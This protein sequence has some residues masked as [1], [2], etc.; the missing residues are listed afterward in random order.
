MSLR[1]GVTVNVIDSSSRFR[2]SL[3]SDYFWF[4]FTIVFK[5]EGRC[6]ILGCG[7]RRN[8]LP[9]CSAII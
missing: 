2:G 3:R 7:S 1:G 6:E 4:S 5:L 8:G 9:F